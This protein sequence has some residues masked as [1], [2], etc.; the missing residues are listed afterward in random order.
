MATEKQDIIRAAIQLELDGRKFYLG[1]AGGSSNDL[2][3]QMFE[4]LADDELIHIE[5]IEKL[6][7][8]KETARELKESIESG[9]NDKA[10]REYDYLMGLIELE[11]GNYSASAGHLDKG[12]SLLPAENDAWDA[13]AKFSF[14]LGQAY[15]KAGDLNKAQAAYEEILPM[16]NGRIFYP[17]LYCLAFLELGKVFQDK[18]NTSRAIEYY[19]KFLTLW[20]DADPGLPEVEDAKKRLAGLKSH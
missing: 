7:A 16:T 15:Y 20:K 18:G 3:R 8:E 4:S 6:S 1:A 2:A 10:I 12:R 11:K 19:E 14:A 5:W 17:E 9:L 13:H